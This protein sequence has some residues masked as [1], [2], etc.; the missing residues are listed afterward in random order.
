MKIFHKMILIIL[1][2]TLLFGVSTIVHIKKSTTALQEKIGKSYS[3]LA[4]ETIS[5]I[6]WNI[7]NRLEWLRSCS[8]DVL[9]HNAIEESNLMFAAIEDIDAYINQ[10]DKAWTNAAPRE[11]TPFMAEL[12]E[13]DT[14]REL[15]EKSEFY[16][17]KYGYNVFGE[18]FVTNKY[19]ANI[20]QTGKTTDYRQNDE[21]WW[22]KT[23]QNGLYC[24]DVTI[25]ASAG[26]KVLSL[27]VRIDNEQGEFIGVIKA[28]LNIQEVAIFIQNVHQQ[29][30]EASA[31]IKLAARDGAI[32]YSTEGVEPFGRVDHKLW[33]SMKQNAGTRHFIAEG[34]LAD[35]GDELFAW[36]ASTGYKDY[37]G[38]NWVLILE[39]ETE[40][41]FAPVAQ[42]KNNL[43]ISYGVMALLALGIG[44][45][46]SRSFSNNIT[47]LRDAMAAVGQGNMGAGITIQSKDEIGELGQSFQM[48]TLNLAQAT[49][50]LKD[51]EEKYRVIYDKAANLIL[52]LD[53]QGTVINCNN[54]VKR[55]LGYTPEELIGQSMK[56]FVHPD[57]RAT[58]RRNLQSILTRGHSFNNEYKLIRKDGT[59]V[60]V[61]ANSTALKDDYG[62]FYRTLTV[63][64]DITESKQAAEALENERN[65]LF[66]MFDAIDE[67]IYV[68][69]P[70]TYEML[71][72]NS[73]AQAAWGNKTGEKCHKILQNSDTPCSFC[74]NNK[75]FGE[76]QGQ[77]YIWEYQNKINHHFYRC[78]D[79][80]I[81]WPD[82]R[83][84]RFELAI[85]FTEQKKAEGKLE[86]T[87]RELEQA[88]RELEVSILRANQM[89]EEAMVANRAKS[90]F[91]AN[92]SHE[93]RTPMNGV[94]GMTELL[95]E[96]DLNEEQQDY[97]ET[98]SHSAQALMTVLN[99]I[100]DYSKIESGKLALESIDFDLIQAVHDITELY[101][102]AAR[103]KGLE[104]QVHFDDNTPRRA[105]GDPVRIR[106]VLSNLIS[107]AI[108]FTETGHIHIELNAEELNVK[109][110]SLRFSVTDTGIGISAEQQKV[111]FEK[112][113]QADTS[114]TRKYGGT[115]LGLAISK[116]LVEL[117]NGRIGMESL[118]N[119]GSTF[120][121]RLTLPLVNQIKKVD[122]SSH[123]TLAVP[124]R[125]DRV[126][127]RVL[128]VEDSETN[129][130]VASNMLE[131]LG[132]KVE[133]AVNGLEALEKLETA[134]Y[135]II[136]MD[137]QMPVYDGYETTAEIRRRQ[138]RQSH[139]PIVAMTAHAMTGDRQKCLEAGMDDYIAKPVKKIALEEMLKKQ[140]KT[141]TA[142]T[143][144]TE[145]TSQK[146][147]TPA[148]ES[149]VNTDNLDFDPAVLLE[150]L[151]GDLNAVRDIVATFMDGVQT[152][153]EQ[154]HEAVSS[155]NNE[156]IARQA[157][158]IKGSAANIGAAVISETA[159]KIENAT[160]ADSVKVGDMV[161]QLETNIMQF[162]RIFDD[163][164]RQTL[165]QNK[166]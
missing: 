77:T 43:L 24:S 125:D 83:W 63:V 20:A 52:S 2:I 56:I 133:I 146:E 105:L 14:S 98:V 135:D 138:G 70:D 145:K 12:I 163:Y 22:Q 82:G 80:A 46:L 79:K 142:N 88:N 32:I 92:M 73:V 7:Y 71:F 100:L 5:Q 103:K 57:C 66:S 148:I 164:N 75:I 39:Y 49:M 110:A 152:E 166:K 74:S 93:I 65:Q 6:D 29:M 86:Q 23:A 89:A 28:V 11:I 94:I 153:L 156:Q 16:Q 137:C 111:I 15:R 104:Y 34:D 36:S 64:S 154:L 35:E 97:I 58:A 128:L 9:L 134:S 72:M 40:E 10:K 51:S 126:S 162:S 119:E 47:K 155:Q 141:E 59:A 25:D 158:K 37:A 42:M 33:Q 124:A 106:Q 121:F 150:L 144:Q 21:I 96:T 147:T 38:L 68:A 120:W 157:H 117:M 76:N 127:A 132:C 160:D 44:Y 27:G 95:L 50:A 109:E 87:N 114:T 159:L 53:K 149:P 1:L 140:L 115:G 54:H 131:T 69:D 31:D 4:S 26:M 90:E 60:D 48:M 3:T 78:I 85:D 165:D 136:F 8:K 45:C 18:I 19:G 91:L 81:R 61:S 62:E 151:N 84:V 107:N 130:K 13:N 129:Q 112:F 113:T 101:T 99:D 116:Q 143:N 102:F 139:T 41:I 30:P 118:S 161:Q 55:L 122:S 67:V 108:K 17:N 123:D